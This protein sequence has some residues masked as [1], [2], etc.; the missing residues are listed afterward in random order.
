MARFLQRRDGIGGVSEEVEARDD[1]KAVILKRQNLQIALFKTC[2]R[3][4][5]AGDLQ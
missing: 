1:I 3:Q 2:G 4:A 5:V